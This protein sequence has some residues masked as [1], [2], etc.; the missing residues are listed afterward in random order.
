MAG[1]LELA[2][3]A[4]TVLATGVIRDRWA[5]VALAAGGVGALGAVSETADQGL[6]FGI[7]SLVAAAVFAVMFVAVMTRVLRQQAVTI[8]TL[9]G[10]VCAYE[11]LGFLFAGIYGGFG[12]LAS[13]PFFGGPVNRS[14]YSYFSYITLTTAGFG[15]YTAKG[16]LARRF[17]AI[18][19]VVGQVFIA[20]TLARLVALF[21]GPS[22]DGREPASG[23]PEGD[24]GGP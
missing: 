13:R 19:A 15:D 6:V 24:R 18:E 23:T 4:L 9:F 14:T 17:V 21:K 3:L 7:A 5:Q 1:A 10:A 16:D 2:A 11:L 8:Q 12:G 22:R 20:T